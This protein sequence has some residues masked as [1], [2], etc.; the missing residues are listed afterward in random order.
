[1][2]E[3]RIN[4]RFVGRVNPQQQ[5]NYSSKNPRRAASAFNGHPRRKP[6][7]RSKTKADAHPEEDVLEERLPDQ[8]LAASLASD[9][10]LRDVV[11]ASRWIRSRMFSPLPERA[12]GMNSTRIAE[13]LNFRRSL[14]PMVT[15]PHLHAV[16]HAPT[17]TE[18]EIAALTK[19]GV[20]RKV[21]IPGRGVGAVSIGDGVLL[22]DD[23]ERMMKETAEVDEHVR[24]FLTASNHSWSSSDVLASSG[25]GSTGTVISLSNVASRAASGSL[26]ATGGENAIHDQGGGGVGSYLSN[27]NSIQTTGRAQSMAQV[28]YADAEF[29][30][31]L[32]N[33][34]SY[35]RL[36]ASARAHMISLLSKSKYREAPLSLLRERWTGGVAHDDPA[37]R[38]KKARGELVAVLPG[39]TRKWRQF[40]GLS[41]EWVLEECVGAGSIELFETGSVGQAARA[42]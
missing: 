39:R 20:L 34:G 8:G 32:P 11:Q 30:P 24:G 16:L 12:S 10:N 37:S 1:M 13:V 6:V 41:F 15:V 33:M 14:P 2:G 3:S 29:R 19:A 22:M 9:A 5:A 7:E 36:L 25:P 38:S 4:G 17:T 27:R 31:S 18:R 35:L 42:T 23:L 28:Q 21:T 40:H 26:A